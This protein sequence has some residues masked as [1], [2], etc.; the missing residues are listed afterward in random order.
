MCVY[1]RSKFQVSSIIL[2]SFRQMG[3]G[4]F[5][6]NPPTHTPTLKRTPKK[7]TQIRVKQFAPDLNSLILKTLLLNNSIDKG[8]GRFFMNKV[9]YDMRS[10]LNDLNSGTGPDRVYSFFFHEADETF[11]ICLM[12]KF[13][14]LDVKFSN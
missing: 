10:N 12:L 3:G 14:K 11:Y 5:T 13:Q 7:P 9:L 1:L 8:H 4:N 2:T 6:P